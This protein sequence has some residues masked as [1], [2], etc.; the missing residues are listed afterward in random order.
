VLK[1]RGL[2]DTT[3]CKVR[4]SSAGLSRMESALLNVIEAQR[5]I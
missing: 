4:L 2:V 1:E 5:A 3:E